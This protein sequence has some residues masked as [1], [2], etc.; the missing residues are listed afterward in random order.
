MRDVLEK[1]VDALRAGRPA[2]YVLLVE[3]RGSTPQKAGAAMLLFEDGSQVGTLG[4]GC[5]EAEVKRRALRCVGR[6]GAELLTFQLDNDYGWD[7]GLI[8]GGRMTV[9]VDSV[10][11]DQDVAFFQTYRRLLE[12]G[13]GCVEAVVLQPQRAGAGEV[14]DRYLFG[15]DGRLVAQRARGERPRSLTE[16]LKPVSERP[17]PYVAAG[18]AY[19]TQPERYKLLIVGA[20]HIGQKVAELAAQVDF[21]VWVVDD[22]EEYCN[23][24]RFPTAK[25]LTVGPI[26][27]TLQQLDVDANTLCVVV[28]RGHRHD[29]QALFHL[30]QKPARYV[31]MIGS[32]RKV[33]LI[34]SDLLEQGIDRKRLAR[35]HAPIGLPI[36]SQSVAEIAVSIVA[37]LIA[38]RNLGSVP[39]RLRSPSLL[40]ELS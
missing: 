35:V 14:G 5:V 16:H 26:D 28:T 19:L 36:G 2:A 20:G 30:V 27:E 21:E 25:R 3:T 4:G 24:Q 17:R 6:P 11:P 39:D 37:E 9:L 29:E 7:D 22:R 23:R 8:C 32:K 38:C 1:T 31:G 40:D 15:P 34:L 13:G 18:I 33:K 10:L 12:Q